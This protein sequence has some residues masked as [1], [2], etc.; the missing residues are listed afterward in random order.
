[1]LGDVVGALTSAP[2]R[3]CPQVHGRR[4]KSG[5]VLRTWVTNV[6]FECFE[7]FHFLVGEKGVLTSSIVDLGRCTDEQPPRPFVNGA[8]GVSDADGDDRAVIA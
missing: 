8:E 6:R 7:F 4:V 2:P 3:K 1:M 5:G